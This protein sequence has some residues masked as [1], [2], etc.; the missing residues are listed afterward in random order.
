MPWH[1]ISVTTDENTAPFLADAFSELGAVSVT[2][3]DAENEAVY[4]PAIGETKIWSHT[5]VVALYELT[6]DPDAIV[7]EIT[8]RFL[9]VALENW[10]IQR[11]DTPV[12]SM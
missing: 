2:Y 8:A 3:M 1:Q 7:K 6:A 5:E 4:E 11:R 10:R 12:H 9:P